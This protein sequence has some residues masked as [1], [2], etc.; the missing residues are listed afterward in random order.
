LPIRYT[1]VLQT[2]HVPFVAGLPFF[3][4]TCT[5]LR[6]SRLLLHLT[7]YASMNAS[8]VELGTSYPST[9]RN[10][11][12]KTLYAHV[13]VLFPDESQLDITRG[14]YVGLPYTSAWAGRYLPKWHNSQVS[15]LPIAWRPAASLVDVATSIGPHH[16]G[17]FH[18]VRGLPALDATHVVFFSRRT[19][20]MWLLLFHTASGK[21]ALHELRQGHMIDQIPLKEIGYVWYCS[22][23]ARES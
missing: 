11:R 15:S 12:P 9:M 21:P 5:G 19:K 18:T 16:E 13:F 2:G 8:C 1:P 17:A 4:V 14:T 3:I 7:Q 22:S 23:P 6:I 10:A 20:S